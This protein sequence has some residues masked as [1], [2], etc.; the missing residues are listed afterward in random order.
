MGHGSP[1][2]SKAVLQR[3]PNFSTP[4]QTQEKIS[5]HPANNATENADIVAAGKQGYFTT[6]DVRPSIP[7]NWP[8]PAQRKRAD[9]TIQFAATSKCWFSL[10]SQVQQLSLRNHAVR[11]A[12]ALSYISRLPHISKA[13]TPSI[14]GPG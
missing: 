6:S 14:C 12:V 2:T 9:S 8:S 7:V 13:S 3:H 5:T 1:A 4:S 10:G 11:N